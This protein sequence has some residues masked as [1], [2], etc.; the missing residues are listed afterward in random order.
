[1]DTLFLINKMRDEINII[2]AKL[3]KIQVETLSE[4]VFTF[5]NGFTGTIE[6]YADTLGLELNENTANILG[7]IE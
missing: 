3:K 2:E 1:M 7:E 6:E 4:T 5:K